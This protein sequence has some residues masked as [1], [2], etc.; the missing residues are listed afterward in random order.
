MWSVV[1]AVLGTALWAWLTMLFAGMIG[2]PIGFV[3]S[4]IPGFFVVN[5]WMAVSTAADRIVDAVRH[6]GVRGAR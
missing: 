5:L 6:A 3:P 4:L 2:H 1:G